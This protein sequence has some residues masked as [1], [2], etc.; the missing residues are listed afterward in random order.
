MQIYYKVS[1]REN[2]VFNKQINDD[3]SMDYPLTESHCE[4]SETTQK[5]AL[6]T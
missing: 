1:D 4:R 5:P 2:K 3:N 6:L